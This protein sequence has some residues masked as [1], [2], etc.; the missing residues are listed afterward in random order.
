MS[1][2][3]NTTSHK[4][5]HIHIS[6]HIHMHMHM[7]MYMH[8]HIHT[9]TCAYTCTRPYTYTCHRRG[10]VGEMAQ[11]PGLRGPLR[12]HGRVLQWECQPRQKQTLNM[13]THTHVWGE[14]VY[15]N[16]FTYVRIWVHQMNIENKSRGCSTVSLWLIDTQN[17]FTHIKKSIN[18]IFFMHL[19][20]EAPYCILYRLSRWSIFV[21]SLHYVVLYDFLYF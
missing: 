2:H 21:T 5:T 6:V 9:Y 14:V 1:M 3:I 15:T 11:A 7:H 20:I 17:L 8:M 4:H 19:R 10:L 18:N 12:I 16:M 13:K